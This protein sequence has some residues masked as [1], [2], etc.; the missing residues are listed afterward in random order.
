MICLMMRLMT[1]DY[2]IT[3]E[4]KWDYN[5]AFETLELCWKY[6]THCIFQRHMKRKPNC[7]M[8]SL[9]NSR[10]Q[11]FQFGWLSHHLFQ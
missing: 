3:E 8:S 4:E 7:K 10:S 6:K 1:Y 5:E 2:E 9:D 11:I